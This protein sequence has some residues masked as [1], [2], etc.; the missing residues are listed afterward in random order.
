MSVNKVI[1]LGRLGSDPE[2]FNGE[3]N[4]EPYKIVSCSLATN[5]KWKDKN[6]EQKEHTEWHRLVFRKGLA[7]VAEK[8]LK[9]AS[10]IYIEGSL[11]TRTKEKDGVT[12]YFT[13]V[14]VQHLEM[15]DS[16]A[17]SRPPIESE[18]DDDLPF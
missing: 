6:N 9:K 14:Y 2:I 5:L 11:R 17:N 7:E 8:Y 13:S 4:G 15:L 18:V 16:K 12:N 3:N 1:L 10:R